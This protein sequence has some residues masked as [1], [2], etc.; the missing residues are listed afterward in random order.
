MDEVKVLTSDNLLIFL[1]ILVA[2][3]TLF[4]LFVNVVESARKLKK[5][6]ENKENNLT[7]HQDECQKRFDH[8]YQML[9]DHAERI[10][11][12]EETTHVLCAGIHALLEHELHNGNSDE[13][14]AAS[15]VLFRHLNK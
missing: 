9:N 15:D 13:M 12:V 11:D 1:L 3:A 6:Q 7:S 2:L 5:P 14:R 10:E 4:I 8:D